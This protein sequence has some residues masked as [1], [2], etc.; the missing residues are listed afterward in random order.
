MQRPN[1]PG[2]A[3]KTI[4]RAA[5][6]AM[7]MISGGAYAADP[8]PVDASIENLAISL[9]ETPAQ[10]A[11]VARF[12][13]SKAEEA[14]KAAERHRSMAM[15]YGGRREVYA[16]HCRNLARLYSEMAAEYSALADGHR[17]SSN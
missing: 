14:R 5:V 13:S 16:V 3:S 6:V 4:A 11:A 1:I 17:A 15:S 9:A 8:L 10:H 2:G 7:L 12:Y